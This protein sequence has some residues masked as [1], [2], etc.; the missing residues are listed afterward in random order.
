MDGRK[1]TN[2]DA[3]DYRFAEK[4]KLPLAFANEQLASVVKIEKFD[5]KTAGFG[6][7]AADPNGLQ[8]GVGTALVGAS[9]AWAL[10]EG[11]SEM[12]IEMFAP[13]IRTPIS[14]YYMIDTQY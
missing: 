9:E 3:G 12:E 14:S 8:R 11:F 1:R 7:L 2:I 5:S 13:K 6:M 4:R 10:A